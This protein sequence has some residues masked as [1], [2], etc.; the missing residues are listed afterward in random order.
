MSIHRWLAKVSSQS[1]PKYKYL[2]RYF[3]TRPFNLLDIGAG[4]HSAAHLKLAMPNCRY[5][6]IDRVRDYANSPEDFALMERFWELD[7]T[8]LEFEAI[9]DNFFDAM[10]MT[11]VIEHL[12]N[13]DDV[14]KALV[15]KLRHGGLIYIEFPSTRST[16]LPSMAG[17]L[18]FY[19]DPTHCRL[20][21]VDELTQALSES[22][23]EIKSSGVRRDWWR[24]VLMPAT[25]PYHRVKRGSLVASDF[26]DVMGFADYVLALRLDGRERDRRAHEGRGAGV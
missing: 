19:D 6:G 1:I 5:H 26:W 7:L 4:N 12:P 11:H 16:R 21:T 3:G 24:I 18:N 2:K 15:P 9:P 17:T 14:L 13:G 22:G 25:V 10:L 23:C 8:R 20:Y